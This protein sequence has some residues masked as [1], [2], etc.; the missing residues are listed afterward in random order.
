MNIK[1]IRQIK[2]NGVFVKKDTPLTVDDKEGQTLIDSKCAVPFFRSG[3]SIVKKE[4]TERDTHATIPTIASSIDD[5]NSG[6]ENGK[7]QEDPQGTNDE[8]KTSTSEDFDNDSQPP[9]DVSNFRII[10]ENTES[11]G[12]NAGPY[13]IP[14]IDH[15]IIDILVNGGYKSIDDLKSVSLE[16]LV[17][18]PKIGYNKAKKIVEYVKSL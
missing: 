10:E 17:A 13:Q 3:L 15:L 9:V 16:S 14:G 6:T 7:N 18:L 12:C 8:D 2:R 5:K 1:L 11:T 4:N